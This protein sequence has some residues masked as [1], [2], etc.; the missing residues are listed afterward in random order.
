MMDRSDN[1]AVPLNLKLIFGCCITLIAALGISFYIIEEKQE[2][3]IMTQ[4]ENEA[5]V[6]F[7]Q[8]VITRKWI[9]DHGGIYIEKLPW[10][11]P[12]PYLKYPEITD[13]KGVKYLKETPA[14]VTKDLSRYAKE[15]GLYWFHITSLKLTN[16]ANAPDEFERKALMQFEDKQT[17]EMFNIEKIQNREY[18]RFISPLY[19]EQPCLS[20]HAWQGY[21]IGDVRGAISITIPI[22]KTLAEISANK[23]NMFVAGAVTIGTLMIA[24]FMMMRK[25]V[26]TPVRKLKSYIKALSD[27]SYSRDRILRTGDEFED[28]SRSFSDMAGKLSDYHD[29]LNDRIKAA[30]LDIEETNKKLT[31]ANAMLNEMNIRKSDFI[32]RASHELRTPLTSIKGA[33]D[34]I[35]AKLSFIPEQYN[36]D[37]SSIADIQT[38][39]DIINK[40]SERLIRMVNDMLDL[41]RIE[42]GS[43][44]LF[45]TNTNMLTLISETVSYFQVEAGKKGVRFNLEL[46]ES[47]TADMDEDRIRQVM[48]NLISNALKFSPEGGEITISA[49]KDNGYVTVSVADQGTG[50]SPE[51]QEK[52][53]EKFFKLGGKKDGAGL[54]LAVCKS[55]IEA[56]GGTVGVINNDDAGAKFYFTIPLAQQSASINI[57]ETRVLDAA[58]H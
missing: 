41:E 46:Q 37:K 11:K 7:Q 48:I 44:E 39:L 16:P 10:K 31:E 13:Q 56:H 26:L 14:M 5:R 27:G 28:L 53:F 15:K 6:I 19:I 29:S 4:V 40:N 45:F 34:F 52:V 51:H 58:Q 12:S 21:K 47:I 32:A 42:A 55:I 43:S 18:L 35:S 49:A 25:L 33:M 22:D 17:K 36:I 8:I 3:L 9:A 24:L 57:K 38:F 50:V 30:T 54:G 1:M 23:K 2:R 20:C